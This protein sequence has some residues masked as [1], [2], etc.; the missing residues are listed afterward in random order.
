[1]KSIDVLIIGAG[2]Y[3]LS[4][5]SSLHARGIEFL[6]FGKP[7]GSWA[8]NMPPGMLLKSYPWASSLY[9]EHERSTAKHFCNERAIPYHDTMLPLS[10]ETFLAY[11][12]DFQARFVPNVEP[13]SLRL[14]VR[15]D[16]GFRA[17]FAD[18]Q[19]VEARRVVIAV[20]LQPFRRI[21]TSLCHLPP[22]LWSHS[23][24]YGSLDDFID[25][26]VTIIGHG[27]SATDLA[28]LLHEAGANVSLVARAEE[29]SFARPPRHRGLLERMIAPDSGIGEG[30]TLKLCADAPRLIRLLPDRWRHDLAYTRALGPLGGAF[31]SGK[32]LGKVRTL[33]GRQ[34]TGAQQRDGRVYLH[35]CDGRGTTQILR[36]SHVI[37]A[38]G[39][40]IDVSRLTFLEKRISA[41]LRAR[42]GAP[43]LSADYESSVPGLHFI[44]PISASSFGPVARFVFGTRHPSQRMPR[45]FAREL[46]RKFSPGSRLGALTPVVSE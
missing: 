33:M 14:L 18:G 4:L 38:T 45:Y 15:S 1:M 28:G 26:D 20:G 39:Y 43:V 17:D 2:P 24:Q 19:A 27:S 6:I 44:G 42:A 10:R 41:D 21:P 29:L 37:A 5:A 34:V 3:G 46:V 25:G 12:R 8:E 32:V 23:G 16:R 36:T 13:A 22:E 9:G 7:M 40:Q 30:W 11:G 31:M 35:L